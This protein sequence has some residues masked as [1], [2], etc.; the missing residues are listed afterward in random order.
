M[1][2]TIVIL[3]IIILIALAGYFILFFG[4]SPPSATQSLNPENI[5]NEVTIKNLSFSPSALNIKSG[6]IIIWRNDDSVP[7]NIKSAGFN[8]QTL[9]PGDSFQFQFKTSGT[10]DYSCGIHPEMKG[11]IIVN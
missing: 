2:K 9:N 5:V 3:I 4:D 11:K 6:G 8:S 1:N 7:H 10:F